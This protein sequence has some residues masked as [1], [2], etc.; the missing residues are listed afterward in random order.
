MQAKEREGI[1]L[2]CLYPCKNT[3]YN[4]CV[5][6]GNNITGNLAISQMDRQNI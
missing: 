3:D 6:L 2:W 5:C 4:L 1:K